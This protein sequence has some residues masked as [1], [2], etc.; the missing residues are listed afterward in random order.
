[1]NH[2]NMIA[3]LTS[4]DTPITRKCSNNG[5]TVGLGINSCGID[6]IEPLRLLRCNPLKTEAN[7]WD[8]GYDETDDDWLWLRSSGCSE[9]WTEFGSSKGKLRID[10]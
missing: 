9:E 8:K 10:F 3:I 2:N 4:I 5:T 1:M 6:G 7:P